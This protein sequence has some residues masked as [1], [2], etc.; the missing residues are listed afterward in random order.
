[1]TTN[2]TKLPH[3]YAPEVQGR[4][5]RLGVRILIIANGSFLAAMMFTWFY[6]RNLNTNNAWIPKGVHTFSVG[7]GWS[8]GAGLILAG[9]IHAIGVQNKSLRRVT[10][11]L[12]LV[13]LVIG[14][15]LEWHQMAHMPFIAQDDNSRP[16]Y[17]GAY[18]SS[19]VIMAGTRMFEYFIA[20]FVALGLVIRGAR[21]TNVNPIL[22]EWRQRAAGSWFTW[23]AIA[24]FLSAITISFR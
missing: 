17:N 19:W 1:M 23:V 14:A 16:F 8:A 7:S 20:T 12:V 6:L 22:E 18:A 24:G 4:R 10:S 21:A 13:V 5:E 2:P 15:Y 11:L 3:V 9:V